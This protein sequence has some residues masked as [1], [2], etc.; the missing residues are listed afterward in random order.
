M[1]DALAQLHEIDSINSYR[2]NCARFNIHK[3]GGIGWVPSPR[4]P[5]RR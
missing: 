4:R 2:L 3:N 1:A 5:I